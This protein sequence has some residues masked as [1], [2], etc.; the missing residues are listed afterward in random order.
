M[1]I[2]NSEVFSTNVEL[3]I[4]TLIE[5]FQSLLSDKRIF[6]FRKHSMLFAFSGFSILSS[7]AFQS[8]KSDSYKIPQ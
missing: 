6:V 1:F 3:A 2:E 4:E 8:K 7:S 5:E